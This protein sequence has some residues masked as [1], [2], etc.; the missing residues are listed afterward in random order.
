MGKSDVKSPKN[1]CGT[2]AKPLKLVHVTTIPLTVSFFMRG[3][4]SFMR[5]KGFEISV[6]SSP[7]PELKTIGQREG[8]EVYGVPMERGMAPLADLVSLYR[9][10]RLFRRV[11]PT[12][13]HSSTPK[14]G[15]LGML[16]AFMAR[17]PIRFYTLRGAMI[18]LR[19]GWARS[20]LKMMEWIG[21]HCAHQV[22]AVSPSV[23]DLVVREGLCPAAKVRV[24][25]KGS[26]NGVD[27]ENLFNPC[28][29]DRAARQRVR[30]KYA[31]PE[32]SVVIGFVGRLVQGKGIRELAT[33]WGVLKESHCDAMLLIIGPPE[34][35]DPVPG[36]IL[37]SL[38]RDPRVVMVDFVPKSEMPEHYA[39][40]D[41][42]AF[43]SRTEG[44]PNVPLE[45]AA[46]ELPVVATR[47]TGC[48][49][50]IQEGLTGVLVP[51]GN[52]EALAEAVGNYLAHP[53]LRRIHGKAGRQMVLQD[54][55]P[56]RV[57]EALYLEYSSHLERRGLSI[58]RSIARQDGPVG[59]AVS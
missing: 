15:P 56:D 36:D 46:M 38:K 24:L 25:G 9:L 41:L 10:W 4:V 18:D 33:A 21:C 59:T 32:K 19:Q 45:A 14:A 22:L 20:I 40:M 57:W 6:V 52:P 16:A 54:F 30:I 1:Q 51:P 27:A 12:I 39:I 28:R 48:V 50:V 31:I 23:A 55:R 7:E 43:P 34:S 37:S 29:I 5:G 3:Q 49:D 8:I 44:L 42:V 13:V 26:S 2:H 58:A 53:E 47:V 17:V 11:A 35:V